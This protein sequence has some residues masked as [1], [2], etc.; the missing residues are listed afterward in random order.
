MYVKNH[1]L[2]IFY[3]LPEVHKCTINPPSRPIISGV[4]SL[5]CNLFH[6]IDILLQKHESN[7]R[8]CIKDSASLIKLLK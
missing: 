6:Y 8:S 7:L 2:P 3:H 1:A 4:F 5:T